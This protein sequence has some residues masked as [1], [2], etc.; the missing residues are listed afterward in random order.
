MINELVNDFEFQPNHDWFDI[1]GQFLSEE[2]LHKVHAI[3]N[4]NKC[5]FPFT[6]N[7]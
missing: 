3:L 7:F 5:I 6:I 2:L 1:I 4:L